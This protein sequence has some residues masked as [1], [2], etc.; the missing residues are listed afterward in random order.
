VLGGGTK[1]A[2][3]W[4]CRRR[5]ADNVKEVK[6]MERTEMMTKRDPSVDALIEQLASR[7]VEER[8]HARQALA[9]LGSTAVP[10]ITNAL[11]DP[12]RDI[13]WEAAKTLE[14]M[15]FP[16]VASALVQALEDRDMD[17]RWVAADA[18][19]KQGR[20]GALVVLER[21]AEGKN[22]IWMLQGAHHALKALSTEDLEPV[23]EPVVEA[24][25]PGID[26]YGDDVVAIAFRALTQ[27]KQIG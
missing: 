8:H 9:D 20:D 6:E 13:R 24:L 23:L 26:G 2:P 1:V 4:E 3:R 10:A 15:H 11:N 27:L 17:V 25:T 22:S 12:R 7:S 16:L 18:L 19:S 5:V 21:L 14:A